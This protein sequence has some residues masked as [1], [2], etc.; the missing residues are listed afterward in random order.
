MSIAMKR[1][2]TIAFVS[3]LSLF[4]MNAHAKSEVYTKYFSDLA[5][6]GYDTVAY[7][8]Q[9]KPVKGNSKFSI[10]Y[11]DT[12]W[13]FSSKEHLA[14]FKATPEKYAPQYGGYC[15]WAVAQGNMASGDPLKW[16]IVDNKLYLNYDA[17][18]QERWLKDT[19]KFIVDGDKIWPSLIK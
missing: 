12:T 11:K 1:M 5:V 7:F 18:I 14:L 6:S 16:K 19:A 17:E 3:C 10:E 15:A 4:T 8:T 13:L 2:L 9:D